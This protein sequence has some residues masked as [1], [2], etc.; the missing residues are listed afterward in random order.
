[1]IKNEERIIERSL[2]SVENVV[3]AFCVCDTGSSDKTVEIVKKFLETHT[4]CITEEKW[5]DFGHNRTLSFVNAQKYVR[6]TLKWD[7]TQT[8]GIL[9]DADMVFVPGT[10]KE[11]TLG[12]TGYSIIQENGGL[13]YHNCRL[14]RM[15][16]NWKCIGVTHEYWSGPTDNLSK[17][18]C[19]I[20]DKN[21]GGCKHDKFQRDIQ[22]LE[23]GLK[24]EPQNVR[25]MFYLAQSYNSVGRN[26]ESTKMYK[27]RIAAGGWDEEIWYSHYMIA[28]NHKILGNIIKFEEWMLRAYQIRKTRAEPLYKL[29]EHF[30][31]V[32][33]QF[34]AYEYARIGKAIPYPSDTLFVEK[35]VYEGLFDYEISILDY[36]VHT[37]NG[38]LS[39]MTAMLKCPNYIGNIVSNLKFYAK[40]IPNSKVTPLILPKP[41]GDDYNPSAISV[42]NYPY[43]NVRYVNYWMDNG[44]YLTKNNVPVQTQNA[45]VNLENTSDIT[46]MKEDSIGFMKYE[47]NVQGLEDI[48]VSSDGHFLATSVYEYLKDNITILHGDY[49]YTQGTY[50]NVK[51]MISPTNRKCEKNWLFLPDS[52]KVIYD[53]HPFQIGIIKDD[54]LEIEQIHNTP[55]FFTRIR[56]SAPPVNFEQSLLVLVHFI[57]FEHNTNIRRYYHCF[58]KLDNKTLKPLEISL[59]FVFQ[60]VSVEYC[61]SMTIDNNTITC[62]ASYMDSKPVKV[63]FDYNELKW[64]SI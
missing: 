27:K 2:K 43:A 31:I 47:S 60:S 15:D 55:S 35:H 22:L 48:R 36:Y 10:L 30:R 16:Y 17:D 26:K 4:G 45:Y 44:N 7:L 34:K 20:D 41:F 52:T 24:D 63:M 40:P 11:Q 57:D 38:T 28:Q 39:S 51:L 23:K 42:M 62:Y 21:D 37:A 59:P 53:W 1:M 25:Y 46:L 8:Y 56:G 14:V 58:I 50:D 33:Q 19:Y 61:V 49:N 6:D 3:D 5:K 12:A 13:S 64:I 18:I 9:L 29:T 32:G 54:K